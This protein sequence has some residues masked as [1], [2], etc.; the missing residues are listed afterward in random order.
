LKEQ[1]KQRADLER[2]RAEVERQHADLERQRAD[3]EKQRAEVE[4]QR[5]DEAQLEIT[6]LKELLRNSGIE[7]PDFPLNNPN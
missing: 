4:K 7:V 5:A 1:E 6:R 2:Q 3:L